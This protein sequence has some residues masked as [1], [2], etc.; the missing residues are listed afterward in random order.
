M[1]DRT[2]RLRAARQSRHAPLVA[3]SLLAALRA[4]IQSWTCD[5]RRRCEAWAATTSFVTGSFV[6]ERVSVQQWWE[7]VESECLRTGVRGGR[8]LVTGR[9]VRP[10]WVLVAAAPIE[11]WVRVLPAD[12][13]LPL[14]GERLTDACARISW[15]SPTG[16]ARAVRTG[17]GLMVAGD[18]DQLSQLREDDLRTPARGANG[19]DILDAALCDLGVFTRSRRRGTTRHQARPPKTIEELVDA[20]VPEPFRPVT[21]L[22]MTMYSQ[23]ISN[24]YSTIRTKIRSLAY[25]WTYLAQQHPEIALC[26]QILPHHARGF[27]P[28]ALSTARSLQR[29]TATEGT[30]DRTTTYDWM[31]DVRSFFTDL[32]TWGTE[33]GSPLAQ[34]MPVAVP[35]TSHDLNREGFASARARAAARMTA[36]V[37]DLNRELPNIRAFALRRWHE[38]S[39]RLAADQDDP[40]HIRAERD[41]FWDWALLELLLT[42][43]LRVEEASE[44]TTLDV[45][46]RQL[47]DGRIYYLMHIKPSKYDRARV[48]PIGDG[49]GRVIAEIIAHVKAFYRSDAVPACDRRDNTAK[50]PLPSAPYLLQGAGHPSA[51]SIQTIRGRLQEMS[52]AAG[53]RHVDGTPLRLSPHDCRRVFAT[54]HLNNNTPVHVIAALLGHAGLDTVMIYAKLYPDSLVDGYRAAMR[55]RYSDVYDV[56]ALRAPTAQEWATFAASCSLRDM[57]THVCAL[58]TGEHCSRGLVCLGCVHAQPKKTAA[59]VFRRMIASHTRALAK[60]RDLAEPAGQLAARELELDRLRS[61][62]RRA[63]ELDDDVAIALESAR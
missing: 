53:A 11:R 42:S 29:S 1:T 39:E 21:I 28:W 38:A 6:G 8:A 43:G 12:D 15:A 51:M 63:E 13:P 10:S 7:A 3:E 45:L 52:V 19:T 57:G 56:D 2:A 41:T 14:A 18:Y 61:A 33:P 20:R 5:P 58:P 35:L 26:Q 23:R 27:V 60:A 44:L 50:T 55:G 49:L 22:Y 36:T 30:E 16:R 32:C 47:P 54:E 25:F 48:I 34:H 17:I 46:K 62:L 40:G 24:N 59:P 9:F 4:E 37:M 31:V